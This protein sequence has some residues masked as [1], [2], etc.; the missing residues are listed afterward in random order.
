MIKLTTKRY[1]LD[2]SII[3]FKNFNSIKPDRRYQ[4]KPLA[5]SCDRALRLHLPVAQECIKIYN[6]SFN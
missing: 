4:Y 2:I 5:K 1:Y 3:Y 6:T